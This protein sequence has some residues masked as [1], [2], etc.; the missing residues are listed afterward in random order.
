MG[1]TFASLWIGQ[2]PNGTGSGGAYILLIMHCWHYCRRSWRSMYIRS[3]WI[4]ILTLL[5]MFCLYDLYLFCQGHVT[6][7]VRDE[8]CNVLG[9][10]M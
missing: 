4:L 2:R 1:Y 7:Y 10:H 8:S 9:G 5:L 6:T 3:T